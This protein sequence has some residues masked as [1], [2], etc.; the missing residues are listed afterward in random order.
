MNEEKIKKIAKSITNEYKK[1]FVMPIVTVDGM[2]EVEIHSIKIFVN[3]TKT[4]KVNDVIIA[5]KKRQKPHLPKPPVIKHDKNNFPSYPLDKVKE[6][7]NNTP[8]NVIFE[9]RPDSILKEFKVERQ[10]AIK[11]LKNL[12]P[13]EYI[14]TDR[15]NGKKP[16][17]VYHKYE[18]INHC[19]L[20]L[21]I[22][23]R[24]DDNDLLI[25]ISIHESSYKRSKNY[26]GK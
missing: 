12:Q 16:A 2:E 20:N 11:I 7:L 26:K 10:H 3:T 9:D 23:L 18:K 15:E 13:S 17:D 8:I 6:I 25:I 19:D 4:N 21:Y 22:K 1:A 24:I 5:G 14:Q